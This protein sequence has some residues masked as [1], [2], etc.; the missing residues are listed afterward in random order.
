[1]IPL[2]DAQAIGWGPPNLILVAWRLSLD[3]VKPQAIGGFR[4]FNAVMDTHQH[5][6]LPECPV[7]E[8]S[9]GSS[10]RGG[11]ASDLNGNGA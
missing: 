8:H 10:T 5:V 9:L 7:N 1:M 3:P 11:M 2:K 4:I 6:M